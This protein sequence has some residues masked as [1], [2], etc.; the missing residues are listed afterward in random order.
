MLV[1]PDASYVIELD[2]TELN[3]IELVQKE[4]VLFHLA[5]LLTSIFRCFCIETDAICRHTSL[6]HC[7]SCVMHY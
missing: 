6:L 1:S 4:H 3:G 2:Q 5:T 7:I